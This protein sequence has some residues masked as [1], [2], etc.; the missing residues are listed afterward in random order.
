M[1]KILNGEILKVQAKCREKAAENDYNAAKHLM[2]KNDIS[3][4][5]LVGFLKSSRTHLKKSISYINRLITEFSDVL[6]TEDLQKELLEIKKTLGEVENII[7]TV[8][9]PK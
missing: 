3:V 8:E 1:N 4:E 5:V 9:I 2:E 6:D 7:A